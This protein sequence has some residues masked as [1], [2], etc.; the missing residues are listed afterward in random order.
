VLLQDV[1]QRVSHD[2]DTSWA[3]NAVITP[4]ECLLNLLFACKAETF[5]H[6][7]TKG[8]AATQGTNA[9]ESLVQ[10]NGGPAR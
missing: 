10:R 6:E 1:S 8:V 7:P 5:G 2:L 4:A 3:P 9:A